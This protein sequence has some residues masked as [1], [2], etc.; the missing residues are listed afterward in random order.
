MEFNQ[1]SFN[2][3]EEEEQMGYAQEQIDAFQDEVYQ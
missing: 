3:V 2:I 1:G